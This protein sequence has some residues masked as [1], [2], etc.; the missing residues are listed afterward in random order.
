[1]V[2]GDVGDF[3]PARNTGIWELPVQVSFERLS[4]VPAKAGVVPAPQSPRES[5][6]CLLGEP[7]LPLPSSAPVVETKTGS[8]PGRWYHDHMSGLDLNP[9][10]AH[11]M[12]PE[13]GHVTKNNRS[14]VSVWC[15]S[16]RAGPTTT[17]TRRSFNLAASTERMASIP[18]DHL[19]P[20]L[21][22]SKWRP[23]VSAAN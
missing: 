16:N 8:S 12:V 15:F 2:P 22:R 1:M 17:N 14:L 18:A 11:R 20:F 19:G 4:L 9:N 13:F 10:L 7:E 5:G 23:Q 3:W 6:R 21:S